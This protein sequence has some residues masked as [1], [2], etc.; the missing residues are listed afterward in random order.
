[1]HSQ[2]NIAMRLKT[3]G[4]RVCSF[5]LSNDAVESMGVGW[6]LDGWIEDGDDESNLEQISDLISL[7]QSM[8]K[9]TGARGARV[10]P[11]RV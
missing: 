9:F 1:V 2:N 5:G 3:T 8:R 4:Q 7:M 11:S 10:L 6:M